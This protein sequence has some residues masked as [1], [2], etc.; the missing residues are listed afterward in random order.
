MASSMISKQLNSLY[1]DFTAYFPT[2][3]T[4]QES[5]QKIFGMFQDKASFMPE[6]DNAILDNCL[7]IC[8]DATQSLQIADPKSMFSQFL[9]EIWQNIGVASSA[10]VEK[11][12]DSI[13][14]LES[15]VAAAGSKVYLQE[16]QSALEQESSLT[17]KNDLKSLK[18]SLSDV[19]KGMAGSKELDSLR[20]SLLHLETESKNQKKMLAE[21]MNLLAKIEP[22]LAAIS[23]AAESKNTQPDVKQKAPE[24]K[25]SK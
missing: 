12:R 18:K 3:G 17:R 20:E 13:G 16:I 4:F 15:S 5:W 22:N 11:V 10:Q 6:M 2:F 21:V 23:S 9:E 8:K 24:A 25:N 19:K 14:T 7:K 1:P